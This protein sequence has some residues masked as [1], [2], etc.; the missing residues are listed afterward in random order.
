MTTKDDALQLALNWLESSNF[1]YP[2]ELR[3]AIRSALA[4]QPK[5][6]QCGETCERAELCAICAR[7]LEQPTQQQEP[8]KT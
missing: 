8:S 2:T 6:N 5:T 7:E 4:E 3:T 1:V